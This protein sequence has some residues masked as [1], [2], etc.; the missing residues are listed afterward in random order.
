VLL[1]C[2]FLGVGVGVG[3]GVV[4]VVG[5]ETSRQEVEEVDRRR[6]VR[7]AGP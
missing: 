7:G 4:E 3:V 5:E 2:S 6:F 1:L